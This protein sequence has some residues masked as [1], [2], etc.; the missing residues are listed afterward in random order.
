VTAVLRERIARLG[1]RETPLL[2]PDEYRLRP[3]FYLPERSLDW[4]RDAGTQVVVSSSYA[5]GR[6][7][8]NPTTPDQDAWYRALF[9][10]PE[11]FRVEPGPGRPGPTIR[12]FQLAPFE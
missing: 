12:I 5:Y 6:Y 1:E 8:G 7:L 4:Y 3:R 11:I 2:M 10:L 9:T